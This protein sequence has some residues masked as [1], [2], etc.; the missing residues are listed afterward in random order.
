LFLYLFT[1][2][3][4]CSWLFWK[5]AVLVLLIPC[6]H[7]YWF[8][9]WRGASNFLYASLKYSYS[10]VSNPCHLTFLILFTLFEWVHPILW[11]NK[12]LQTIRFQINDY[13]TPFPWFSKQFSLVVP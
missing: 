10:L 12:N 9:Q 5:H 6:L 3:I 2:C 11:I 7:D 1:L 8:L 13:P 4:H